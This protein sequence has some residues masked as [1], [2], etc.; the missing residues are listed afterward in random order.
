V[1]ICSVN[2]E[3]MNDW[4]TPDAD[5]DVTWRAQFTRDGQTKRLS[6]IS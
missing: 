5:P 2:G 3:W 1:R 6:G 4:F